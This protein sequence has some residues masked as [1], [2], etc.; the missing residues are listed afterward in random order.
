MKIGII[1]AL[2]C[3]MVEFCRDFCAVQSE[4]FGI[5]K[6]KCGG[7]DVYISLAG[8]GKVNAA[9]NTQR[10][11]DLFGVDYVINSGVAGCTCKSL[12]VCDIVIS[13]KLTYHDFT[14]IDVLDKYAPYS[15]VFKADE[16]LISLAKDAC[17]KIEDENFRFDT[18]M[19]VT[20]DQFIEDSNIV[21]R[22]REDYNAYC[23]EM[24]GAAVAHVCVLNKVPFVVIRA[25]SDNADEGADM[26]FEE[27]AAIAA[28]R[29][30]FVSTYIILNL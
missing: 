30:S 7:H 28:K 6:G 1:A 23:T 4:Y 12:G 11:I 5:F 29:A 17:T 19:I 20:G 9:A 8:V 26:S 3:E 10:L 16:R 18:G 24:E 15:S 27:M 13:D 2:D 21:A 14:P 25:M 22:L